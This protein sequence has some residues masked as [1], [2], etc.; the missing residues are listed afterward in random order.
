MFINIPKFKIHILNGNNVVEIIVFYGYYENM[1]ELPVLFRENQHDNVFRVSYA[2]SDVI[3]DSPFIF[4]DDELDIINRNNI[5]V[6]F[7]HFLINEDDTIETIKNKLFIVHPIYSV[8]Q[9]YF[10]SKL[11]DYRTLGLDLQL[12]QANPFLLV[13]EEFELNVNNKWMTPTTNNNLFVCYY[14]NVKT[15]LSPDK[16]RWLDQYFPNRDEIINPDKI[17]SLETFYNKIDMF[18]NIFQNKKNDI[19]YLKTGGDIIGF[20]HMDFIIPGNNQIPVRSIFNISHCTERMPM[21]K[22]NTPK[23]SLNIFKFFTKEVTKSGIKIPFSSVASMNLFNNEIDKRLSVCYFINDGMFICQLFENGDIRVLLNVKSELSIHQCLDEINKG[24]DEIFNPLLLFFTQMKISKPIISLTFLKSI[25]FANL[26]CVIKVSDREL[27]LPYKCIRPVFAVENTTA[28]T[29]SLLY[30]RIPNFNLQ[31]SMESCIEATIRRKKKIRVDDIID[32]LIDNYNVTKENASNIFESFYREYKEKERLGRKLLLMYPGLPISITMNP[33]ESINIF[34]ITKISHLQI[35]KTLF[36]FIDSMIRISKTDH[37]TYPLKFIRRNCATKTEIVEVPY[38]TP[39]VA[40]LDISP[41]LDSPRLDSSRLDSPR[42][43]SPVNSRQGSP[44]QTEA[45]KE[46]LESLFA[47][48]S[49]DEEESE[50]IEEEEEIQYGGENVEERRKRLMEDKEYVGK[51][52]ANSSLHNYFARRMEKY[53][54]DIFKNQTEGRGYTSDCQS[55]QKRQPV[56]LNKQELD[57]IKRENPELL[58]EKND[59]ILQYTTQEG[60]DLYYIC[61]RYWCLLDNTPMTQEQVDS[62]QCGKIIDKKGVEQGKYV[63]EFFHKDVHG[64]KEKYKQMGPG[65]MKTGLPCCFSNWKSE[66]QKLLMTKSDQTYRFYNEEPL[67]TV[68]EKIAP[69]EPIKKYD[70]FVV[71]QTDKFPLDEYTWSYPPKS[72]Q[73]FFNDFNE[74]HEISELDHTI[75]KNEL[76]IMRH[77]IENN[78]QKSF[79]SC[80]ADIKY[81]NNGI[82]LKRTESYTNQLIS[83]M[84]SITLDIFITLQNG[85]LIETFAEPKRDIDMSEFAGTKIYSALQGSDELTKI[86]SAYKNYIDFLTGDNYVDYTYTWDLMT[87]PEII[88]A[89]G[90]N[91]VIFE[92]EDEMRIKLLCP[93][94]H[95]SGSFFN[96]QKKSVVILKSGVFFE[97]LFTFIKRPEVKTNPYFDTSSDLPQHIKDAFAIISSKLKGCSPLKSVLYD[98]EQPI[99]LSFLLEKCKSKGMKPIQVI[100][101]RGKVVGVK[102]YKG[103]NQEGFLPCFPSSINDKYDYVLL[104]NAEWNTYSETI[105]F[106]KL[107]ENDVPSKIYLQL[108][109]DGQIIG[110]LTIT[111]QFVP[112]EPIE[113]AQITSDIKTSFSYNHYNVDNALLANDLDN[114]R[115]EYITKIKKEFELENIFC[116]YLI[117]LLNESKE[118]LQQIIALTKPII[119]E[120]YGIRSIIELLKTIPNVVFIE[121]Y[122]DHMFERTRKCFVEEPPIY[123]PSENETRYYTKLAT[124]IFRY[125]FIQQNLQNV[126]AYFMF[127]PVN[128][129]IHKDEIYIMQN[130]IS[131]N[132]FLFFKRIPFRKSSMKET[133]DMVEPKTVLKYDTNVNFVDLITVKSPCQEKKT[134]LR[135]DTWGEFFAKN[136][137]EVSFTSTDDITCSFMFAISIINQIVPYPVDKAAILDILDKEYFAQM[138]KCARLNVNDCYKRL[139]DILKNEGKRAIINSFILKGVPEDKIIHNMIQGEYYLTVTD[140]WLL[141]D[142]FKIPA[143]FLSSYEMKNAHNQKI[144]FIN[145]GKSTRY[146]FIIVP[147]QTKIPKYKYISLDSEIFLD[148]DTFCQKSGVEMINIDFYEYIRN[149][150]LKKIVIVDS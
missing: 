35:I 79:L 24:I 129:V 125:Q 100:N 99:L 126:N 54:K 117:Y 18:Y 62:G 130:F 142:Y 27:K 135:N 143:V 121:N 76:C 113:W 101:V 128:L 31:S 103:D 64:T 61:P 141:F 56:V 71:V 30:K 136:T 26:T 72:I 66:R 73:I 47:N 91:L 68:R 70:K 5:A 10:M 123:F 94:N 90:V 1:N 19:N 57:M 21:I 25:V 150:R 84:T 45:E 106:L 77:G 28:N 2:N 49:D 93:A 87:R 86:C 20:K 12:F 3:D 43:V 32:N 146:V 51:L 69:K 16:E 39:I 41:R 6:S 46:F 40:E 33:L 116:S 111:N 48:D 131:D 23:K 105:A 52:L 148:I 137:M 95:Y 133:Y 89:N 44:E 60:D 88:F 80:I 112:I 13:E 83:L 118:I 139:I 81:F 114:E 140:L 58:N 120:E 29:A 108:V 67:I 115:I 134:T 22:Y 104:D 59:E 65:I 147:K 74:D 82:K 78:P 34:E 149:H 85:V 63:V 42:P 50:N 55:S 92:L 107:M 14:E 7:V 109:E 145:N 122:T 127:N 8:N 124:Y 17:L 132:A 53:D 75:K 110:F 98:F 37:T 119:I 96:P 138:E 15:F 144:F 4:S 9:M 36:V 11:E 38:E 97:P 102:M